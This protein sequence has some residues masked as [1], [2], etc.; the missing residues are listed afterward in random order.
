MNKLQEKRKEAGLSQS[1]LANKAGVP[2]RTLQHWENGD[3]D[4]RKAAVETVLALA[5]ALGCSLYYIIIDSPGGHPYNNNR[6]G[7]QLFLKS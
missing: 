3:R 2:V 1:Q 6:G 7:S 4:L 5:E